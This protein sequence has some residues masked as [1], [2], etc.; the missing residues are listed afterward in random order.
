MATDN[1]INSREQHRTSRTL[2]FLYCLFLVL[3]LVLLGRI[4]YL[5][6]I[7]DPNDETIYL[8]HFQPRKYM[9]EIEPERGAIMD[10]N[11]KLL[12]FSTPM[13]NVNMDC[14]ILKDDF[15]KDEKEGKE[16][17]AAW[18]AEAKKMAFGIAEVLQENGKDG[19][20][21]YNLIISNRDS[22]SASGRKNKPIARNIDHSTLL[23][24][25]ELPL[26]CEGQFKSG[27]IIRKVD[28]R[29][30]PYGELARRVI[31]DVKVDP[32]DPVANR[33][34]GIE[35][36]YDHILHGKK[37]IEWMKRTDKG[38]IRNVDSTSTA[39]EHGRDI[40][41]TID[42]DIQDI[43]DRALRA[44]IQENPEVQGG[45]IVVM[46]VETGAV[47]AMVNLSR[48]SRNSMG[49]YF[50]SA[51]GRP[52]EP[53]SVFKTVSLLTLI[54][55][56]YVE[57]ETKIPSNHGIMKE[58]PKLRD[59]YIP[60]YESRN[61]TNQI[62]IVD[63]FEI[64]SNYVFRRLVK[65]Y[66]GKD[67][68]EFIDRLYEY[69]L[70]PDAYKFDLTEKGATPAYIPDPKGKGWSGTDL[71]SVAIGYTV[72]QPALNIAM[73]YNAIANDGKMMKPYIVESI[74]YN[75]R[76]EKRFKPEILNGS[77]CSKATADSVTRALKM[78]TLEGT[79]SKLK[80]A[81]CV[82]AGKTGTA[83]IVLNKEERGGSS[84]PFI[85][86]NGQKKHQGTF[87]GFFP[88]DNPKYTAIVTIWS[89][90]TSQNFYGGAYPAAAFKE[91]VDAVWSL[92]TSWG[93][94][95][96]TSGKVP[97]MKAGF[98]ETEKGTGLPVPDLK[99]MGLKDAI[100]AIENNG[101]R[102]SYEGIGHVVKQTPAAGTEYKK[103]QTISIVLK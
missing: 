20:W 47:K 27:M 92:D 64:S 4:I 21:Y 51:I 3:S 46:E 60:R 62:S 38:M 79:A 41:T 12:A 94:E 85:N 50:N 65:D 57:L 90:L 88:A 58:Y 69:K 102:C 71:I 77:I 55:D 66:Y 31:G 14:T 34:V 39:V 37:G 42:I 52:A 44:Q 23:K 33:F 98:I 82:V 29:Q 9:H 17:E 18:R 87:V 24:L 91:I 1:N 99:G 56:G 48:N 45:C 7:W 67:E 78:V 2:W 49:E 11:G 95:H 54:E 93:E 26:F 43:A 10:C 103:G 30:Y 13:Y 8:H 15:A 100:Y 53:G 22:R 83:R 28:T 86:S 5:Q 16:K 101:Y 80:N 72:R 81:K 61:K 97:Q 84:D 70:A 36:Q 63:G 59:E 40:R 76:T 89:G 96:A 32:K 74:E 73:F 25:Q 19:N 75:G 6:L 68:K 35:G